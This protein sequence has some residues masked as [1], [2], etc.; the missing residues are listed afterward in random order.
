MKK[1]YMDMHRMGP[2]KV[3]AA[4]VAEAHLKDLAVQGRHGVHFER[5]WVDEAEGIVYCLA[6]APDAASVTRAHAEAHG[7]LPDYVGEVTPGE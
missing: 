5:Y 6:H 7:L 1:L 4:A 3:T 2:G